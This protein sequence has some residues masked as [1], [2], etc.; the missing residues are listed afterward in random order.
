MNINKV[1]L[2][3]RITADPELRMSTSNVPVMGFT[4]AVNKPKKK[5]GTQEAN[6]IDCV[7]FNK[8]AEFINKYFKKGSL[9]IVFG[10]INTGTYEKDGKKF[11]STK[12]IVDEVQFGESKKETASPDIPAA[13]FF[14][15]IRDMDEDLP[16]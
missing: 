7:A 13:D 16:F 14:S 9:I 3:G 10:Q 1:I 8:T 15:D 6:F 2:M 12:I 4:I 5:D 11:K